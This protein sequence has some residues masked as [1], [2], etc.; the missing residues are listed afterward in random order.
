M[1]VEGV[2]V[3]LIVPMVTLGSVLRDGRDPDGVE[4]HVL[5]VVEVVFDAFPGSA[6]VFFGPDVA[7][8]CGGV[9]GASE[10]VGEDL[11]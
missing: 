5:D 10:A 7:G 2:K 6:A 3:G 8:G 9:V 4:A 1:M 11:V